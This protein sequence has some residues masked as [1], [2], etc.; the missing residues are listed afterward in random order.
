M[1]NHGCTW[2]PRPTTDPHTIVVSDR[3][4]MRFEFFN[5]NPAAPDT[6]EWYKTVDMEPALGAGTL[7]CNMRMNH[8]AKYD[9][10]REVLNTERQSQ[11]HSLSRTVIPSSKGPLV[12]H[13]PQQCGATFG[14]GHLPFNLTLTH[15]HTLLITYTCC[16][17]QIK[18]TQD[19]DFSYSFSDSL[20]HCHSCRFLCGHSSLHSHSYSDCHSALCLL[21]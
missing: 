19:K 9:P 1:E 3:R 6:F 5:Y 15:S 21:L 16:Y 4:N 7:P 2:D 18:G 14:F 17:D 20:T 8:G 12:K 13:N 11:C 10:A